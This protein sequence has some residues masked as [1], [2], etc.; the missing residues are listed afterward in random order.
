ME[1]ARTAVIKLFILAYFFEYSKG[2]DVS[3]R[4]YCKRS[5]LGDQDCYF[6]VREHWD[7]LKFRKWLDNLD[8]LGDVSL[9]ITCTE[10]GSLYIPWPMRARNLKRLEIKNCLLRGYFD[11][12]DVKSRYP[13]SLEVRS[14][15]NS[16]T[17]VSLLDWVNV[18]KSMQS[19]KSY[20][21]GQETLV[22]SIVSNN[23]YSFL[24]I[25]KLPGSKMLELLSEISDSFREKG[26]HVKFMD[27]C[28]KRFWS[29]Q[30]C[31]FKLLALNLSSNPIWHLP[32][33]LQR[34]VEKFPQLE[35]LDLSNCKL[36]SFSFA[37]PTP[38]GREKA[39]YINM[40][41]NNISEVPTDFPR[42]STWSPPILIDLYGNPIP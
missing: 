21:C 17:E 11:E 23:T 36:Q 20:T 34:W 42:Y 3:F 4:R 38:H 2:I 10:G 7:F 39:I 31:F 30:D 37:K 24:N 15:V 40:Q 12:H 19:E 29:D 41:N 32:E 27:S 6:K 16:V 14:I 28:K 13:D 8:P 1:N 5:F 26:S 25:P 33:E 9:R 35:Y 22:R 18:V